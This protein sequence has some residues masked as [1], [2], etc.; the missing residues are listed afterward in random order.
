MEWREVREA[1]EAIKV[2]YP[3]IANASAIAM[4][5][6]DFEP[7]YE[8]SVS[9]YDP[10]ELCRLPDYFRGIPVRSRIHHEIMSIS[11]QRGVKQQLI[12]L[13]KRKGTSVSQM[14]GEWINEKLRYVG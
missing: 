7:P 12:A 8:L 1:A 10:N 14:L 11:L 3:F 5:E 9:V 2:D 4:G 6:R 13:A